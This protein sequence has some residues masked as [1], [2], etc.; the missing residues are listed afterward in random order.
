MNFHNISLCIKCQFYDEKT[1][2]CTCGND[3]NFSTSVLDVLP[4]C[5]DF[6]VKDRLV[7]F[8]G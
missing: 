4:H 8:G 6:L 5:D 7:F 1:K 2:K 3:I